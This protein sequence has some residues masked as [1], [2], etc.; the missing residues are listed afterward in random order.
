[1]VGPKKPDEKAFKKAIGDT[2]P[3]RQTIDEY[4]HVEYGDIT[5]EWSHYSKNPAGFSG[6]G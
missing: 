3:V 2:W 1:M 6:S 5:S 4:L